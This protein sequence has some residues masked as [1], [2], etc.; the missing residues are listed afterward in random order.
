MR[1]LSRHGILRIDR[2]NIEYQSNQSEH[3]TN[4]EKNKIQDPL[5]TYAADVTEK[6]IPQCSILI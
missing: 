1:T 3:K 4:S 2:P 6:K 5:E